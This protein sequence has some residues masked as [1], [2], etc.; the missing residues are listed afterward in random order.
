VAVLAAL[1]LRMYQ[2][3]MWVQAGIKNGILEI[4]L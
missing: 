1:S 3:L 4:H 2:I